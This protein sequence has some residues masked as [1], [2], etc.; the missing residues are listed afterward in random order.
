MKEKIYE[1][2]ADKLTTTA[3]QQLL[4]KDYSLPLQEIGHAVKEAFPSSERKRIHSSWYYCGIRQKQK[5]NQCDVE[6]KPND[7]LNDKAIT[8]KVTAPY[9]IPSMNICREALKFCEE[10]MIGSGTFGTCFSGIY[11][12]L[13]VAVKV[14]KAHQNYPSVHREVD[15]MTKIP[16]HPNVAML[17]GVCTITYPL[18]LLT[19]LCTTSGR[20]KT[21]SEFLRQYEKNNTL[22][23]DMILP[24]IYE[25]SLPI[26]HLHSN[27]ILHNDIKGNNF[28]IEDNSHRNK[29]VLIDFGKATLIAKSEGMYCFFKHFWISPPVHS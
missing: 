2:A 17:L 16:S 26:C 29:P 7:V 3:V 13:P 15:L 6:K 25:M 23:T 21:Y 10:N 14:F 5:K 11:N 24:I 20:P 4:E 18:L 8:C 1:S 19:K 22:T 12:G 9:K 27:G 28:V